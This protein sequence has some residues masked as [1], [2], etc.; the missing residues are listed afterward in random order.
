MLCNSIPIFKAILRF[1]AASPAIASGSERRYIQTL[2]PLLYNS[3]AAAKPSPPLFPFPDITVIFFSFTEPSLSSTILVMPSAAFSIRRRVG[4]PNSSLARLSI[5]CISRAVATYTIFFS[6]H[7][8][9]SL[10]FTY[11]PSSTTCAMAYDSSWAILIWIFTMPIDL[12][13][14]IDFP[15]RTISG[16]PL[17][18]F[19]T[20]IS[21]QTIP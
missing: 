9:Y 17:S 11:L 10:L 20:S 18:L 21:F 12:A 13:S 4:I 19:I 8:H 16:F 7:T 14:S 3:L 5:F 6:S 2:A 1:V 15:R